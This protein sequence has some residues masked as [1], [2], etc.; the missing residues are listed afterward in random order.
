MSELYISDTNITP[1]ADTVRVGNL[2]GLRVLQMRRFPSHDEEESFGQVGM[3]PLMG[4]VVESEEGLLVLEKLDF[5]S[6]RAG[7]ETALF[8]TALM[9]KKL[10][11]LSDIDLGE[12][13]LTNVSLGGLEDAVRGGG[14]V[15]V[16]S[17]N[18]S[19]N[20]NVEREAWGGFMRAVAQSEIGMPKLKFL[21]PKVTKANLV[22][23]PVSVALSSGKVPSLKKMDVHTFS[24]DRAG[25]GDLGEAVRV[26]AF[27]AH[28]PGISFEL[29]DPPIN[30]DRLF[31]AIGESE[32]GLPSCVPMLDLSGG[33]FSEQ[34][35][36]SLAASV[37]RVSGG[38]L[39]HL[40]CLVLSRCE[41]DDAR[42]GRLAEVF[43][44]HECR[45]LE[46]VYLKDNLTS[47]AGVSVFLETIAQSERGMPKLKRL[48]FLA[49]RPEDH[50]HGGPLAIALTS[51][52]FPSLET[53]KIGSYD[54]L[55][56][57]LSYRGCHS[58]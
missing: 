16:S 45:E 54:L 12:F 27:P 8:G 47:P 37:G 18:L 6:T 22:G 5:S 24:F 35:L 56:R 48:H 29:S 3:D 41:I 25:V 7:E 55:P 13:G 39:S 23:G 1:F 52:K 15:G 32:R 57:G 42:L 40:S 14:L 49:P 10:S 50:L 19:W 53:F 17:L 46:T 4:A 9:S 44:A 43:A 20:E 36:A 2:S 34:A 58:S 51:R 26:G 30:L 38:K 31:R 33:R 28:L 11:R 21:S